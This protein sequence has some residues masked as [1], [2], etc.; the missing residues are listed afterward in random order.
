MGYS[1]RLA[2]SILLY[3]PSHRQ[4]NTYHSLC[5]TSSGTLAQ[6]RNSSMKDWFDDPSHLERM[7]LPELHLTQ[8]MTWIYVSINIQGCERGWNKKN[9]LQLG[10]VLGQIAYPGSNHSEPDEIHPKKCKYYLWFGDSSFDRTLVRGKVVSISEK[11]H[12]GHEQWQC[13]HTDDSGNVCMFE[14]YWFQ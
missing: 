8:N 7:L 1:L 12:V 4:D 11:V 5:Y 13:K 2:A 6:T 9:L 10:W 3:A 14:C